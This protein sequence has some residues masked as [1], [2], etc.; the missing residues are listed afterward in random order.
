MAKLCAKNQILYGPAGTGKTHHLQQLQK[1]YCQQAVQSDSDSFLTELL[2]PLVWRDVLI[3]IMLDMNR[4]AKKAELVAHPFYQCKAALNQRDRRKGAGVWNV[5]SDHSVDLPKT[6]YNVRKPPYVF[7]ALDDNY[8]VIADLNHDDVQEMRELLK[9][10]KQ[11]PVTSRDIERFSFVTFHQSYGYEDFI[12]GLRPVLS[13]EQDDGQVRYEI[14]QGAFVELCE[15]A[16]HDPSHNYAM[17]IDEINRGNVSKIF[18]ELIT[19]IELDKR[20]GQ[21]NAIRVR[22]PYSGEWFS[23]PSNVS[24]Y[25]SMNSADRSLTPLDTAL[26]RRFEFVEMMPD[27]SVLAGRVVDGVALDQLLAVINQRIEL[28]LGRD[29]L[30]GHAYLMSVDTFEQLKT[31]MQQRIV[32]LLQEYFYDDWRKIRWVLNDHRKP[33]QMQFVQQHDAQ[34]QMQALFGVSLDVAVQ[35]SYTLNVAAFDQVDSYRMVIGA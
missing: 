15:R 1:R 23:V 24:V 32:P 21:P 2:R 11:G 9:Q 13:D 25:G 5:L 19:L 27:V 14:K 33:D 29:C 7:A 26:R 18:G 3:L 16:R 6:K 10:I 12:E 17:F 31:V 28:L 35:P 22:L 34:D 8:W 30:L 4:S 20:D